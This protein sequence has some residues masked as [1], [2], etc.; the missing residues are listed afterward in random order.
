MAEHPA[1]LCPTCLL[2]GPC[3]AS[4]SNTLGRGLDHC[5]VRKLQGF[6]KSF[7]NGPV[8]KCL[9]WGRAEF[10]KHG[11]LCRV[12]ALP[13][14]CILVTEGAP[15]AVKR[16]LPHSMVPQSQVHLV[17]TVVSKIFREHSSFE[18]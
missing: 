11:S 14:E 8:I 6:R 1:H 10:G 17:L 15:G 18:G 13:A 16:A 5:Q 2:D 7:R 4:P 12:P 3:G 9:L